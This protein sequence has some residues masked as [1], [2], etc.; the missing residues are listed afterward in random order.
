MP[1]E[2][3]SGTTLT[4]K[5]AFCW[6]RMRRNVYEATAGLAPIASE[7][8]KHVAAV[9]AIEKEIAAAANPIL[10]RRRIC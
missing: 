6:V 4:V 3:G 2:G 1:R 9:Y 10:V 7:A 8:L 5:L